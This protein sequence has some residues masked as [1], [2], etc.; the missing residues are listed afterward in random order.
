MS[1]FK[2]DFVK[3]IY[4]RHKDKIY[5]NYKNEKWKILD[6]SE[7][8]FLIFHRTSRIYIWVKLKKFEFLKRRPK[9]SLES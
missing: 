3:S 9:I 4:N 5:Y 2:L 8:F 7:D 1:Y 6:S